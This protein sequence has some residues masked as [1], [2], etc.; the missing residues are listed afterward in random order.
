ML[1]LR[2]HRIHPI[3]YLKITNLNEANIESPQA[4]M[5]YVFELRREQPIDPA[6]EQLSLE[7]L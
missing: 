1:Y 2:D 7:I 3:N 5:Y 4:V 6:L